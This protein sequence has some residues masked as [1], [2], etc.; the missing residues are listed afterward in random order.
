VRAASSPLWTTICT[1]NTVCICNPQSSGYTL[2][3]W[4]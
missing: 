2:T 3:Y 4:Y 1:C